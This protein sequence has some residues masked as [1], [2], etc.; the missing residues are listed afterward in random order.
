MSRDRLTYCLLTQ[1]DWE[2]D[3]LTAK[4]VVCVTIRPADIQTHTHTQWHR[5]THA[6]A[7][8]GMGSGSFMAVLDLKDSRGQISASSTWRWRGVTLAL[9]L[10]QTTASNYY[11]YH[12]QYYFS[13]LHRLRTVSTLLQLW[14]GKFRDP[15]LRLDRFRF[16]KFGSIRFQSQVLGFVLFSVLVFE[17]HRNA[18]VS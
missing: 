8:P 4:L 11:H 17:H 18:T 14:F 13:H 6:D 10:L 12:D 7:Q 15:N 2:D 3:K 9:T 1:V 5:E 16:F